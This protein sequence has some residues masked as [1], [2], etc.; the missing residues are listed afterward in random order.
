[1]APEQLMHLHLACSHLQ[2]ANYRLWLE[3]FQLRPT[4]QPRSVTQ[5]SQEQYQQVPEQLRSGQERAQEQPPLSLLP[6]LWL[7]HFQLIRSHFRSELR[8]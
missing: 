5:R 8:C 7:A 3:H 2:A 1:M 6:L 4:E